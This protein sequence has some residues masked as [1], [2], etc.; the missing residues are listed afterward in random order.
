LHIFQSY[1]EPIDFYY[2]PSA[3]LE[4]KQPVL[5]HKSV[6]QFAPHPEQ[7]KQVQK[8]GREPKQTQDEPSSGEISDLF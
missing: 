5:A 6:P 2:L 7:P 8:R 3:T 4:M 1:S